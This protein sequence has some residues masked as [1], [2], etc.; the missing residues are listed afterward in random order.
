LRGIE[1][2]TESSLDKKTKSNARK[3]LRKVYGQYFNNDQALLKNISQSSNR[4]LDKYEGD[5]ENDPIQMVN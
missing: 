1:I 2:G 5:L 3:H 4:N